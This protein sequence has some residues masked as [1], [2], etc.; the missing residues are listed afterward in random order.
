MLNKVARQQWSS[1]LLPEG[2][3]IFRLFCISS[4]KKCVFISVFH[5]FSSLNSS[6]FSHCW[7]S[8]NNFLYLPVNPRSSTSDFQHW[9]DIDLLLQQQLS[10]KDSQNSSQHSVSSHR[11]VHTDSPVHP[12]LAPPLNESAAPPAPSQPLPG[13]PQDSL[14]DGTIQRKP[15]PFKIWAQS[16]SMYESRRKYIILWWQVDEGCMGLLARWRTCV[17]LRGTACLGG[18]CWTKIGHVS[19]C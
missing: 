2:E 18:G 8:D 3:E 4:P 12:S 7:A 15:D 14:A 19:K 11:S 9:Y 6:C 5:W 10:R 13:L 17:C 16:R 1:F